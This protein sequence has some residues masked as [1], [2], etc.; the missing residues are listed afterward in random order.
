MLKKQNTNRYILNTSFSNSFN[1]KIILLLFLL[2]FLPLTVLAESLDDAIEKAVKE[3][4][5]NGLDR[6]AKFEMVIEITNANSGKYD[7]DARIIKSTL[8]T[9]LQAEYPNAT[10]ILEESAL[11]GVS[12]KAVLIK[13]TYQPKGNTVFLNLKAIEQTTGELI[14]KAN[15]TYETEKKISED[16]IAVL[17]LEADHLDKSVVKTFTKIFRSALTKTGVFNLV[18]SDAI[19]QADADEIQQQYGCT[20]EECSTIVAESLNATNVITTQ[21]NM[22]TDGIYFLTGS[23]KNIKTGKTLKEE[24][25][26]HDGNLATLESEL[27]NLA[28]KLADTCRGST[29]SE[30]LTQTAPFKDSSDQPLENASQIEE[31]DG[32]P[33]WAWA[34]IGLVT[35]GVLASAS[36]SGDDD[37]SSS[38][39][40][41][42]SSCPSG[43]GNCG[44]A[45]YTW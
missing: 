8:Y 34:G 13:G 29:E 30:F 3:L 39:G 33:W 38:G 26:R 20:R 27:N 10:I 45:E 23:L 41:S 9:T 5:I 36:D 2:L 35:V 4:Q 17:P 25:I 19:D 37:S 42:S 22:V 43:E 1:C 7:K 32:W 6:D 40:G 24:A 11:V 21:Y 28:C 18:N 15:I 16:L 12:Y 44:S 31:D 14:A